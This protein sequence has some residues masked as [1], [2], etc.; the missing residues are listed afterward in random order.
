MGF[1]ELWLGCL[2]HNG[3]VT[4]LIREAHENRGDLAVI[5]LDLCNAY[6]SIPH[7]LV[8]LVLHLYHDPSKIKDPILDYF[9]N[10]RLRVTSVRVTLPWPWIRNNSQLYHLCYPFCIMK[11]KL[12]KAAEMECRGSPSRSGVW[13]PLIRAYMDDL[14]ITASVP[15]SRWILQGLERLITWVRM[16][17]FFFF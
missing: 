6:E 10:F 15:G 8:E 9:Y 14:T 7:K 5:W 16:T 12:A 3:V 4:Q 13:Q 2:D 11:K 1:L 17:F